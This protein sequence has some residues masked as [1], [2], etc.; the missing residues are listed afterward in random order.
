M[1]A[2][3][4]S[5]PEG[6]PVSDRTLAGR[7]AAV[8]LDSP[9]EHEFEE[10]LADSAALAFRVALGVLRNRADAE[11]VAQE[12]LVRAYRNFTRLRDRQRFRAWL[13]RIA[14]RLALD[15]LRSARRRETREA[16]VQEAA[17]PAS[18]VEDVA[19]SSEFR[20]RLA[21]AVEELPE[22]L[23]IVVVLAAIEGRDMDEVS[24]LL[25]L[26]LGTVKSRLFWARKKLAEKLA[27]AVND[28]KAG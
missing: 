5:C 12:S 10:R 28:I 19:A 16:A 25:A 17:R 8:T 15:H 27:W 22:K 20:Q 9:L 18:S 26:P 6:Y 2:L 21:R 7:G 13:A 11:D 23:R 3:A 1:D 24:R 4:A 14:W